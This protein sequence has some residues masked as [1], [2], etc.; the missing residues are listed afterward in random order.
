MDW[1]T[2]ILIIVCGISVGVGL[3]VTIFGNKLEKS[4]YRK[5]E[6]DAAPQYSEGLNLYKRTLLNRDADPQ[7]F[8]TRNFVPLKKDAIFSERNE[9]VKRPKIKEEDLEE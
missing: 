9:Q 8:L 2:I 7:D 5:I 4:E 6:G 3:V 1:I